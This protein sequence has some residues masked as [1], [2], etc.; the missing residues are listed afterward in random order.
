[1]ASTTQWS[2]FHARH[3]SVPNRSFVDPADLERQRCGIKGLFCCLSTLVG[4]GAML[5]NSSKSQRR[6]QRQTAAP[7]AASYGPP[8][9]LR[10]DNNDEFGFSFSPPRA[11]PRQK[12]PQGKYVT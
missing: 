2:D 7:A 5:S 3:G 6:A 10:Y 4:G 1:M 9:H 11:M 12:Q 8:G